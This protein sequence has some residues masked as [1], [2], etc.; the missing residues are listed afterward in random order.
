VGD[1]I[2]YNGKSY[3]CA[4]AHVSAD[5]FAQ[6]QAVIDPSGF[7][8][9]EEQWTRTESLA[10]LG[11]PRR[12]AYFSTDRGRRSVEFAI[13]ILRKFL[14]SRARCVELSFD[15]PWALARDLT[16]DDS[17]RIETSRIPG[18]EATGKLVRLELRA[19]DHGTRVASLTVACAV[20]TGDP[21]PAPDYGLSDYFDDD[22]VVTSYDGTIPLAD[23]VTDSGVVYEWPTLT[24][25]TPV[26]AF[27]L[28]DRPYAVLASE[29]RNMANSQI[30]EARWAGL[31]GGN[32]VQALAEHPTRLDLRLRPLP[33]S[34]LKRLKYVVACKPMVCPRGINL[35]ATA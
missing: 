5:F 31:T 20:G 8:H 19:D 10:P 12:P 7:S 32:P 30:L 28:S 15:V 33:Q 13:E 18:G 21:A 29:W 27:R 6:F 4:I 3:I 17:I 24:P 26:N 35:G 22:F 34:D 11:D 25:S 1:R 2:Q 16:V 14:L 9:L 23:R